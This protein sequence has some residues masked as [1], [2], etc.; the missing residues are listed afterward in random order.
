[1][2]LFVVLTNVGVVAVG[3]SF[4]VSKIVRFFFI[5]NIDID[6]DNAKYIWLRVCRC[7]RENEWML[8]CSCNR[9]THEIYNSN[10]RILKK[11]TVGSL[12]KKYSLKTFLK[13]FNF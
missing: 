1:M 6:K 12:Y 8:N 10:T 13:I 3:L 11:G 5:V 4:V 9:N 2:I 7:V